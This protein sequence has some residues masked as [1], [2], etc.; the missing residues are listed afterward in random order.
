MDPNGKETWYI[1]GAGVDGA[2]IQSM[3]NELTSVGISNVK[4]AP[5][6]YASFGN[7]AFD[8][9]LVVKWNQYL[10]ESFYSRYQGKINL[11]IPE[12]EQ[13]NFIGYSHGTIVAAQ[14]ALSVAAGGQHV[15][16]VVLIGAPINQDLLDA[17]EGNTN[18]GNV[19]VMNLGDK[20]DPIFAGMTDSE[21][22]SSVPKLIGQMPKGEGHFYYAPEGNEGDARRAG[23]ATEIKQ[24]GLE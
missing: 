6:K 20:G 17:L 16:N 15:D 19:H 4:A 3:V 5:S 8:A 18:I 22:I 11:N 2:Y 24:L 10:G 7:M 13:L 14:T 12:G 9:G 1:G 23:L 21:I